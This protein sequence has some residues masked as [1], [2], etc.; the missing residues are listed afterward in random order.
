MSK[1]STDVLFAQEFADKRCF[2]FRGEFKH[3]NTLAIGLISELLIKQGW[4]LATQ[5][6][7]LGYSGVIKP[8]RFYQTF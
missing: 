5:Q 3:F 4:Q 2:L 8:D 7:Q 6:A 1:S